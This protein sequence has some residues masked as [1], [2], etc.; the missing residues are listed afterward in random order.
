MDVC[1]GGGS[2]EVFGLVGMIRILASG[3]TVGSGVGFEVF[4]SNFWTFLS[5]F[6]PRSHLHAIL[7]SAWSAHPSPSPL[8]HELPQ[9]SGAAPPAPMFLSQD[10]DEIVVRSAWDH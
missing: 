8:P 9:G 6:C 10:R 3:F 7:K 4:G 5:P 2:Q 1:S